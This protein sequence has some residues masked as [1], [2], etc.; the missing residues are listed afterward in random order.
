MQDCG[1][2]NLMEGDSCFSVNITKNLV[3]NDE[4]KCHCCD[5]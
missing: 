5:I 3:K 1:G 4:T 2:G